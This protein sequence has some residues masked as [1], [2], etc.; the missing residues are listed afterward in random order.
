MLQSF[1]A[2]YED[3]VL[4][5]MA[6]LPLNEHEKVRVFLA[7]G[8]PTIPGIRSGTELVTYWKQ[9]GLIGSRADIRDS[10]RHARDLRA[11]SD[12]RQRP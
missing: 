1:D 12:R 6:P 3:G 10:Q 9:A 8:G 4:K 2:I 5:P 11:K 7:N